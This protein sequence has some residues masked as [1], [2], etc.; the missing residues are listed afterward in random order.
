MATD[1]KIKHSTRKTQN[2]QTM[3]EQVGKDEERQRAKLESLRR[4]LQTARIAADEA[5]GKC[6]CLVSKAHPFTI[7][8][9]C[10]QRHI[11][12]RH[13]IILHSAR[14]VLLNIALCESISSFKA[15][16][17]VHI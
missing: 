15:A 3:R 1:E 4:D 11:V 12:A 16:P 2:A 6:G 14:K 10:Y 13:K 5:A 17:I 8:V 9:L 7:C